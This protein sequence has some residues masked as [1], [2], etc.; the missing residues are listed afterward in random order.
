MLGAW[1]CWFV[2]VNFDAAVIGDHARTQNGFGS[3]LAG[4]VFNGLICQTRGLA[5]G[6]QGRAS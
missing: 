3:E 4:F 1:W 2:D 6:W 5:D